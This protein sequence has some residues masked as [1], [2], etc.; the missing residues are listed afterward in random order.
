MIFITNE[1]TIDFEKD[2]DFILKTVEY[3]QKSI[4]RNTKENVIGRNGNFTFKDG[5]NNKEIRVVLSGGGSLKLSERRIKAREIAAE[6]NKTGK[7]IL[8]YETNIFYEVNVLNNVVVLFNR[9][10]DIMTIAFDAQPIALSVIQEDLTWDTADIAW[11]V[12]DIP[13]DGDT[14]NFDIVGTSQTFDVINNG[15]VASMPIIKLSGTFLNTITISRSGGESFT[16]DNLDGD[17]YVDCNTFIVYDDLDVNRMT[18]FNGDFMTLP[19]GTSSITISAASSMNITAEFINKD[20][21]V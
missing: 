1:K 15:N 14:I 19:V 13:W 6:L 20:F 3:P 12:A 4:T 7:L 21:Y 17:I 16:I 10:F 9:T 2:Y 18:D 8:D 5:L 11:D